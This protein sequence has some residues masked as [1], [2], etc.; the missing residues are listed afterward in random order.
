MLTRSRNDEGAEIVAEDYEPSNKNEATILEELHP[1]DEGMINRG[2][3]PT[4]A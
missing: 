1:V 4:N 2:T 3:I